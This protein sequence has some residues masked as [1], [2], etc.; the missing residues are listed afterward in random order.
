MMM[1]IVIV[2]ASKFDNNNNSNIAMLS[3]D[4][5]TWAIGIGHSMIIG[6]VG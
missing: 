4:G 2:I 1:M 5:L 6:F 3:M